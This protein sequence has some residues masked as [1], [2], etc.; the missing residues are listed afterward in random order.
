MT[1]DEVIEKLQA[2]KVTHY[3]DVSDMPVVVRT[4]DPSIGPVASAAVDGVH[5]GID[6]DNGKVFIYTKDQLVKKK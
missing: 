6:W 5:V 4:Y 2:L 1:V 3:G